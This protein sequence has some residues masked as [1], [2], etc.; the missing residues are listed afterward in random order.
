MYMLCHAR[1]LYDIYKHQAR[2]RGAYKC[3]IARVA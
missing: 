2:G 3:D 1:V